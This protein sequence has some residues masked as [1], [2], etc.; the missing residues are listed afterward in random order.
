MKV[1]Y[2]QAVWLDKNRGFRVNGAISTERDEAIRMCRSHTLV[3]AGAK[4]HFVDE[5]EE[6]II[7]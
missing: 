7:D 1:K 2:Y 3:R 5:W 6:I 4:L